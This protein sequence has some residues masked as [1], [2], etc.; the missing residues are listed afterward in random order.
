[1]FVVIIFSLLFDLYD[2]D[3]GATGIMIRAATKRCPATTSICSAS[4]AK[5]TTT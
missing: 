2:Y 1:M 3:T 4:R 5:A